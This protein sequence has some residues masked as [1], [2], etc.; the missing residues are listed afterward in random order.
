ML[1]RSQ[2]LMP[3]HKLFIPMAFFNIFNIYQRWR[4]VK[5]YYHK[6]CCCPTKSMPPAGF[7]TA[8]PI[9]PLFLTHFGQLGGRSC[10]VL[11]AFTGSRENTARGW[12]LESWLPGRWLCLMNFVGR[13]GF[14]HFPS[15]VP[16]QGGMHV[17]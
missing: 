14:E 15:P 1:P 6:D 2:E 12:E 16:S 13:M 11:P 17:F 3:V 9:P 5:S 7:R 8:A 10:L 4:H